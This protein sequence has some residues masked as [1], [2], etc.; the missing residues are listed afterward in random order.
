MSRRVAWP[1]GA[2]RS[3]HHRVETDRYFRAFIRY[4]YVSSLRFRYLAGMDGRDIRLIDSF[5]PRVRRSVAD[6]TRARIPPSFFRSVVRS[7]VRSLQPTVRRSD[8]RTSVPSVRLSVR[9][10]FPFRSM[11]SSLVRCVVS[12]G[13]THGGHARS[14]RL[15]LFR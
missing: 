2:D 3:L 13:R 5:R 14:C 8:G 10:S 12:T 11:R 1:R 4:V 15:R 6:G 7:F 9:Q